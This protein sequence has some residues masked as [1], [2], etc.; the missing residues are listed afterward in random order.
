M[1]TIDRKA[2]RI[3]AST[4]ADIRRADAAA[5]RDLEVRRAEIDLARERAQGKRAE[6]LARHKDRQA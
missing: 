5:V 2:V 4:E 1:T 6:R 3:A